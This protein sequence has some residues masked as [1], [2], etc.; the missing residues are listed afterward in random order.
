M[1]KSV[2]I[3][4]CTLWGVSLSAQNENVQYQ[5]LE[6]YSSS[7]AFNPKH[8]AV[9]DLPGYKTLKCDFHL[10][11]YYSDGHV[12]PE[13]RVLEAW[14]EG[15]DA[16]SI[17]DHQPVPRSHT[18]TKDCNVSYNKAFPMAE[19][20]GITLIKGLEITGSD[21]VGHLNVLFIK[22]CNDYMPKKRNFS[23]TEADS[24]I[25]KAA[26][27]GAYITTNHPGWPD[28]NSEL[29]AYIVRHI[30]QKRIQGIEIFNNEEFYPRAIDYADQ[31]NL[32]YIGA[33]DAHY[34]MDFLFD[35]KKKFRTLTF[36]FAKENTPES[37][38]EALY[39][40]RSIA[41]ADQKLAGKE[42][43]LKLFLRSSLKVL[44]YEE[45]NGKFHVRLLN[46]SDIPYLLDNGVLSD[47]IRIPA[48]AVCDMTRP[49]SQLT[50]PFRV[51]NMYIS[52]TER[53]E[54]PVSYLLASKEMP[55]MPYV[56]E[57]KVSF[58]KEGLSIVLSCGEG[59]TY[60]TLDGTEPEFGSASRCEGAIILDAPCKLKACTYK[61]GKPSRVY[62]RYIGF[63]RA[64]KCKGRRQ[65][66]SY[67]Y[68]EGN[69]KSVSDLEKIGEMKAKGVKSYLEFEDDFRNEDH[70]GYVYESFLSVPVSG[71]YGFSL[72]SNDGS[73]LF[74]GGVRVVDNDRAVGYVEAN[75]FVYLEKGCHPLKLRYF[76]G[77]SGEYLL[78][79]WICPKQTYGETVSASCLFVE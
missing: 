45:R 25:E 22:D 33:T 75:G 48:H 24:L 35:L 34:P 11:T 60:Y 39:A 20:K 1:K 78:M 53:L 19:S 16:I 66:A 52:S 27:E 68:Y 7:R 43:M 57:R 40:G 18:E 10:H 17:T 14:A 15:L 6:G 56:D 5:L 42:N 2:F 47:R 61:D 76:D 41:Y 55:E 28:K 31:Y 9:P 37:I 8:I 49:L 67:R 12:T 62:E 23:E 30:E 54:I 26:A 59:D 44:S 74:I 32:A 71:A 46:E 36:V 50:Q 29:P 3:L 77:Y 13:M 64:I 65:G 70:F 69:F 79:E 73:D 51:T 21:P 4:G 72:K 38:K 63:S 58:V